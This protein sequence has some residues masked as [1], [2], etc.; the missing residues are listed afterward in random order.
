[1]KTG[2]HIGSNL[3]AAELANRLD[4][5]E[6]R[7]APRLVFCA[8]LLAGL[9]TLESK[10]S[11]GLDTSPN[12]TGCCDANSNIEGFPPGTTPDQAYGYGYGFGV[13]G[14]QAYA[15]TGNQALDDAFNNGN[16][17]GLEGLDASPPGDCGTACAVCAACA[18]CGG[19]GG[20]GGCG[21]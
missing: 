8:S 13:G 12:P 10:A 18:G 3:T 1:M 17:D 16:I 4:G 5:V 21:G 9:A 14:Q 15:N 6:M 11:A 2:T 19:G 20:C 7:W